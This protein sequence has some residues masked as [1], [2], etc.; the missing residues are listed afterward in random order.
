MNKRIRAI[1][2]ATLAAFVVSSLGIQASAATRSS[3][4]GVTL[5]ADNSKQGTETSKKKGK[6]GKKGSKKKGKKG[7]KGN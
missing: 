6:K 1:V 4:E 7:K 5:G 2:M 3:H